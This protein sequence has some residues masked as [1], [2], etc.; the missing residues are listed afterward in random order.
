MAKSCSLGL[1]IVLASM[2]P[3]CREDDESATS[4]PD[5]DPAPQAALHADLRPD[6]V[7]PP[8]L[9]DAL[10]VTVYCSVDE[11]FAR[12]VLAEFK[13]ASGIE[14]VTVFDSEAGKTTGLVNRIIAES[15]AGRV[16]ADVFWSS[17]LFSTIRLGRMGF[18]A[19]YDSPA[20]S[21][22][23]PRY[24]DAEFR[25]TAMASRGRVIAF[26]PKRTKA[27]EVPTNWRDLAED[28]IASRTA[29]ANP[30]FGTTRGHVAALF[31]FW[32]A[33]VASS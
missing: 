4:N 12:G 17:E 8:I 14:V 26:D 2:I 28:G 13:K 16:R 18:L 5:L 6:V 7:A 27:A 22:I 33:V 20:A 32:G 25:W 11:E 21:D 29:I 1:V 3:G 10:K 24:R 31:A 23:P 15:R 9:H 30:L 19:G